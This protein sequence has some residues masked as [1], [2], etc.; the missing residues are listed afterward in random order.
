MLIDYQN[1]IIYQVDKSVLQNN[2][3]HIAEGEFA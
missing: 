3:F 2:N 1:V